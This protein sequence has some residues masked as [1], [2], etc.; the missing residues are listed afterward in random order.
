MSKIEVNAIEPI[1][2]SSDVLLGGSSK[3]IKFASGTTV[4]FSTNTPTVNGLPLAGTGNGFYS[5]PNNSGAWSSS[6]SISAGTF[7]TI[8]AWENPTT[9]GTG[10]S[11]SSGVITVASAGIY[12]VHMVAESSTTSQ[13][14]QVN[15][16][17]LEGSNNFS[18]GGRMEIANIKCYADLGDNLYLSGAQIISCDAN[19]TIDFK[20]RHDN[21][22]STV[23]IRNGSCSVIQLTTNIS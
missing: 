4:D 7:T 18:A 22:P 9:I 17:T 15:K 12:F 6:Q 21:G 3:N 1:S 19:D 8:T 16:V 23:V 11:Y 5:R 2:G 13:T 20:Y 10:V 14:G